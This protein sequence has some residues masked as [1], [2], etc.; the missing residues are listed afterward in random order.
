MDI[1]GKAGAGLAVGAVL[2]LVGCGSSGSSGNSGSS[3]G[4][5][6]PSAQRSTAQLISQM[7]AAMRDAS[8]MHMAGQINAAGRPAELNLSLLRS[9]DLSGSITENGV[10]LH[11]IGAKGKVYVKATPA[12]LRQLRASR[13]V[14]TLMCGKYVQLSGVE[15]RRLAG[16]LS[17]SNLTQALTGK[18]PRLTRTGTTNVAGQRAIELRGADGSTVDVAAQGK[19]FPLRVVAPPGNHER[20]LFSRWNQVPAPAPP[21]PSE[22]IDLGKLKAGNS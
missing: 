20:V 4:G 22:V 13:A 3:G 12:F 17:M 14:C 19:P 9:G 5:S 8:S 10:P 6:T 7:T 11:L 16:S 21:K 18:L 2:G 1:R 15:G